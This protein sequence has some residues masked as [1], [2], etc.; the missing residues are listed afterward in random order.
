MKERNSAHMH[1]LITKQLRVSP[2]LIMVKKIKIGANIIWYNTL[3]Q[4]NFGTG[5]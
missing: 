2:V 5:G 1:S 3:C 4:Q